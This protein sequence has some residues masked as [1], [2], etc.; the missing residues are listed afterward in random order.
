MSFGAGFTS[1]SKAKSVKQSSPRLT[2]A[3]ISRC[4]S[5]RADNARTR[6]TSRSFGTGFSSTG[7]SNVVKRIPRRLTATAASSSRIVSERSDNA[8]S[9]SST[10]S[11]CELKKKHVQ[12]QSQLHRQ[13]VDDRQ[14]E[15]TKTIKGWSP[16]D[17]W[18]E[19]HNK[20]GAISSARTSN[21]RPCQK[22]QHRRPATSTNKSRRWK[23]T[24][25]NFSVQSSVVKI[26]VHPVGT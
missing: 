21:R 7:K 24:P 16:D 22:Q 18:D 17:W 3:S 8:Q 10:L 9:T 20:H 19:W 15:Q 26:S 6:E 4:L 2:M 25:G 1:T 5:E 11:A 12:E 13:E 23:T 14:H